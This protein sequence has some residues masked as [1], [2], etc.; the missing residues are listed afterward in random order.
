MT[1]AS[2][3]VPIP[4][5]LH[6][7]IDALLAG[8]H[9]D[10]FGVLGPHR[11][12][13]RTVVRVLAPNARHIV[14][15]RADTREELEFQHVREGFFV[16]D[17]GDLPLGQPDAYRLR[18]DWGGAVQETEDAYAFGPL[19]GDL[20]LYLISEGRHESLADCLGSHVTTVQD[21]EGVRFAVWAPNARRVSVVGDFTS[22]DGR[23]YPM[24]LR[25]SAGVWE[26]FIPRL[27]A[28]E[29]YKYEIVGANGN[30]LPLK[31]DPL[32]RQTEVPPATASVVPAPDDFTWTDD[33]W[34][35]ARGARQAPDA[36][37]SVYEVHAGSWLPR[38][39]ESEDSVWERLGDRL[40]PY[41]KDMGFTHI[42]LLPIMEHPFGGSWG[43]QP[44]GV[45]APTAR[46]GKPA[47]FARFIDRCHAAGLGVILD[48]VPAHF[49]TDT[50]GLAQFDGTALYEYSDP[51]EGFHPDWNTLIYNLGRT[52]VRNFMVASALEWVRRYHVDA[53]R[54]DAVASM[55]YRDYSRKAGEWIPNRYGGRENLEAVDFLRDMNATVA[56]LCPGAI[57]V[58]EESTAWPGVTARPED[59]GLGFTYKWNMGWMHDTLRYMHH[60]PVYRSYHHHDMTFGMVYAYSERF[61]LPLSHD[62]VVHGKGSLLNKMPGDRW[63]QFA[64]LRAYYGFMWTHPGRKL[65]FMGGEIAQS[66][67]WNHDASLDWPALDDGLHRGVQQ[68]VRDLNHLYSELTPLHRHDGDPSGFEWVVGDDRGN[69][70]FAY[71]RKDGDRHVLAVSNFTPVPRQDYRIGVPRPGWWRERL[72]TDAGGYG[73]SNVGNGG[74]RHTEEIASHGQAQSLSLTLPP[75][76]TVIFELQG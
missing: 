57:T 4:D 18:I 3:S 75:L 40:V 24:R 1:S 33:A 68:L 11:E 5:A 23:R 49:P 42:E 16:V 47:D 20:D 70:V 48:W 56:K 46:Y 61:I 38:G 13:D 2:T 63:Q 36:P 53:L 9:A 31:A 26:V 59:G 41:A 15:L 55:L 29:R 14:L 66:S 39:G 44:L 17:A 10:P 76:A 62:E 51:R 30:L 8:W 74:G 73:G 12:G 19:L 43:Y 37:I 34:M 54:V 21:V 52:E 22:W 7:D 50:H 69:S 28:G 60:E 25:H 6:R 58:A 67:E 64:N 45:F 72:N 27:Q 35:A 65:L 71:M 32:A